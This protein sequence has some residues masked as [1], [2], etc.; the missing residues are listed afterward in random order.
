MSIEEF[1]LAAN[2]TLKRTALNA[3]IET[4]QEWWH[5][6]QVTADVASADYLLAAIQRTSGTR[7]IAECRDRNHI[8]DTRLHFDRPLSKGPKA[9]AHSKSRAM[10]N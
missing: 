5:F 10:A 2:F 4:L 1:L 6:R 3:V 8:P 7:R 9:H